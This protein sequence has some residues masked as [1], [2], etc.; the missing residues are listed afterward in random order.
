MIEVIRTVLLL[1]AAAALAACDVHDG[2]G[3]AD[4][5]AAHD[6]ATPHEHVHVAPHGGTLVVLQQEV[7]NAELLLDA[8][9]GTLTLWVLDGECENPVRVKQ[10]EVELTVTVGGTA[11]AVRLDAVGDALTG[12]TPGDTSEF[13]AQ[14]DVLR[15]ASDFE[16]S[17]RSL[18]VGSRA[19]QSVGFRYAGAAR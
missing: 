5:H 19:F 13:V 10:L 8:T 18:T 6:H 17:I 4:T 3:D 15:G 7:L 1:T 14:S 11:H 2:V 16:G 9:T 12:E